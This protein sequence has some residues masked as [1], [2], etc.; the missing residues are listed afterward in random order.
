MLT[1]YAQSY[2]PRP[3]SPLVMAPSTTTTP[4]P[5]YLLPSISFRRRSSAQSTSTVSTSPSSSPPTPTSYLTPTPT[6]HLRC[7]KCLTDLIP[8]TSIVS[9]G[10]TGRHGR[11]YLVAPPPRDALLHPPTAAAQVGSTWRPAD[12]PNTF[13]HKPVARQLVTGAHT[14]SDISCVRCGSVLGWKYV[15]AEEEA[16]RY[17]IGKYILETGRVVKSGNGWEE[18]DEEGN[19]GRGCDDEGERD[20][21]VEFDSQDED[22]C[23]DLF[24]GVWSPELAK[25][26]RKKRDFRRT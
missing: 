18:D 23:E 8:T 14:V 22:E 1:A 26:R 13:T 9:K 3:R 7:N 21:E 15:H 19:V 12:L 2:L 6:N 10:F 25:R 5:L 20:D 11:A 17:K 16:Q 4:F 24:S